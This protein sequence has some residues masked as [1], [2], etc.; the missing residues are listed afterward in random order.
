MTRGTNTLTEA[1]SWLVLG[2]AFKPPPIFRTVLSLQELTCAAHGDT[3]CLQAATC[4]QRSEEA[5][6]S[7]PENGSPLSSSS[8]MPTVISLSLSFLRMCKGAQWH[9]LTN[10]AGAAAEEGG[11]GEEP[12]SCYPGCRWAPGSAL[13]LHWALG[14]ALWLLGMQDPQFRKVLESQGPDRS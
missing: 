2:L 11:P 1:L 7:T 10:R 12:L 8:H 14:S 4:R 3:A 5:G 13:H 6:G 9:R